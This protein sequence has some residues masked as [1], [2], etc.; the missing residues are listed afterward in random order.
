M[1]QQQL[2]VNRR[3]FLAGFSAAGLGSTLMPGALAAVAQ[4][5][6]TITL[7]MIEAAQAIAGLSFTRQERERIVEHLNGARSPIPAFDT[8]QIA[9]LANDTQPAFVFNPVP[10][11]K[12]LPSERRPLQRREFDVS[13]PASDDDLA[14]LP[15][16]HLAKLIENRQVKPSE[17]T[18]L[19]L[20][21]LK[22]YDPRL[23]VV[24]T[25]TEELAL[26]QAQRADDEIA[27]GLYRG[28][29]HGIPWGAKDLL[30]VRGTKTTWGMSPYAD[31][32]IDLDSTVFS[33]LSE[34]GAILIA[35][36]STGALA[37]SARWFGGLTR[38][39]WNTEQDASGSSAG[40]GSAT[41]AGLVGFSI[42][43]DTGGSIILP[44]TRNG[45]TGL[46][47]T[48]G[49]VSR[50]GAMA[51]VWTQDTI[52]PMCRSAEDCALVLN[53]IY[54]PDGKDNTLLDVPFNWDATVDVTKLRVGYLR[55]VFEGEIL[56]NPEDP[57]SGSRRRQVRQNNERALGVIRSLGVEVVPFDLPEVPIEA[58]D[59]MRYA[60]TAAAFDDVTRTG[61]L[62]RVEEGPEQSRR[63]NEIR[64]ARFIP[65]V[66]FIQGNRLRMRAME[67]MDES[68]RDLDL[69]IGSNQALT[70]RTG[71][72]VISLPNGFS[73]GSPTGLHLTG[74]L[75]G[76]SEIL[77]LADAFQA[78]TDYHE[79]Q[80]QL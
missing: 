59:F 77:L 39:P 40:P 19:Y 14:F 33:K 18:K 36:L 28:P 17:L 57:T 9:N 29:L 30:A 49:R 4:D 63:P 78:A 79:R 58:I 44:S 11:G 24:V 22:Q 21:R 75:F 3:R 64:S 5:A 74:K 72:P 15:V 60:E 54:G 56:E 73:Q 76:D 52:G 47:P 46:R 69:F 12:T 45:V 55:S 48:F 37:V 42:G 8:L 26:R 61:L 53:A 51:L 16:T 31:R 25:L 68:M 1:D 35:K 23:H 27:D 7:E 67:Q 65:A 41:A 20:A 50:Y 62:T 32:T 10:P 2:A 66:E 34:A 43:T 71:H 6:D 70:N 13:R 38:N 80:P